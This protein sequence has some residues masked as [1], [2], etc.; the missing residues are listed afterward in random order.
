MANLKFPDS[1]YP[2]GIIPP[3]FQQLITLGKKSVTVEVFGV[4][5]ELNTLEEWE[6]RLVEK[7]LNGLDDYTKR[8]IRP[9]E[10]LTH[11]IQSCTIGQQPW[12]FSTEDKKQILRSIL[13]ID[14][15]LIVYYLF[16]AYQILVDVTVEEFNKTYPKIDEELRTAIMGKREEPKEPTPPEPTDGQTQPKNG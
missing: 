9:V 14:S 4:L 2:E 11:S 3:D 6:E 13:L 10:I 16:R 15:P 5:W 7:R 8:K 1:D 12:D